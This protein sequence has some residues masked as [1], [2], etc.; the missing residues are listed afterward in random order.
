MCVP[1][2]PFALTKTYN[3]NSVDLREKFF[4]PYPSLLS[5]SL[6]L[7]HHLCR[8]CLLPFC[9]LFFSFYLTFLFYFNFLIMCPSLIWVRFC[10]ETIYLFS[11]QFILHELS[12]SHLLTSEIF[13]KITPL[14]SLVT[15]HLETRKKILII[16]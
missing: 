4:S 1:I 14:E 16:S 8:K 10:P 13:V 2:F 12:S 15:F 3:P 9:L 5:L 7:A 11:V 6:F